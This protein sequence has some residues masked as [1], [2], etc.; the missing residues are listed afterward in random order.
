MCN[1]Q[2][3]VRAVLSEPDKRF[4][5]RRAIAIV[6]IVDTREIDREVFVVVSSRFLNVRFRVNE[7]DKFSLGWVREKSK[8]WK[9]K[10]TS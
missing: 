3:W 4:N 2:F 6:A 10:K 8:I 7:P 9:K 1:C 5:E